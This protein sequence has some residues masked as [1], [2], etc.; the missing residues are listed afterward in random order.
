MIDFLCQG[1]CDVIAYHAN[2]HE[3]WSEAQAKMKPIKFCYVLLNFM[4][5]I[6]KVWA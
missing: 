2:F 4:N 1:G 5:L 3:G 6:D